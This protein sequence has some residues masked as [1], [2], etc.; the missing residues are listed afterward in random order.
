MVRS[1]PRETARSK[2]RPLRRKGPGMGDRIPTNPHGQGAADGPHR[3]KGRDGNPI[4]EDEKGQLFL[5]LHEAHLRIP[6]P[7]WGQHPDAKT[8]SAFEKL[9]L[10]AIVFAYRRRG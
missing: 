10:F 5:K 1:R 3:F 6:E 4:D 7:E 9:V 8:L 2:A